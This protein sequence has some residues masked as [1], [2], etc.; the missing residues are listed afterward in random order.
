MR[1]LMSQRDLLV[2]T[3]NASGNLDDLA[4]GA[5]RTGPGGPAVAKMP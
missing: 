4:P 1:E 2:G 3:D 5:P